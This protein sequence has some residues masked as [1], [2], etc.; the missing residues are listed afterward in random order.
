M[1]R[2]APILVLALGLLACSD[3][4]REP[5]S[6]AQTETVPSP[7]P[8]IDLDDP[9]ACAAC[10]G[11]VVEEWRTSMH[12]HAH[13]S[14]DPIYAALRSLRMERQGEAIAGECGSCHHP[15]AVQ[16]F[17]S[18]VAAVGVGCRSCHG[19]REVLPDGSD[20]AA[21]AYAEDSRMFGPHDS[22]P[23]ASPVHG[24]GPAAPHLVD[25]VTLCNACHR[26]ARNPAGVATC[27][28]GI[29]HAVQQGPRSCTSCHMPEVEGPSGAVS[30]R[31][32][33]RSHAFLG[34]H[35]ALRSEAWR[36]EEEGAFLRESVGLEARFD[37][38]ALIVILENRTGHG[39]PSGFPGR[40]G[41]VQ[42]LGFDEAD[43]EVFRAWREQPSE[44]PSLMLGRFY[45]DDAGAPAMAA[46]ATEL[47]R[48]SRLRAGEKREARVTVPAGVVRAEVALRYFL[49]PGPAARVLGLAEAP[50]AQPR[51]VAR[52]DARR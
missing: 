35:R 11:A 48:D 20:H 49:L 17:D 1:V 37:E 8:R 9:S 3:C 16:N 33:H 14:R 13:H 40:L 36:S 25:G 45:V 12:A 46:F 24:T 6:G 30:G 29:E 50:E 47:A 4:R 32:T 28:T 15:L 41:V 7:T 43:Q 5:V 26:E 10:H 39:F 34:P 31:A 51:L 2:R 18:P 38:D 21:L 23:G 27:S 42:V 52:A 22:A 44:A 19:V